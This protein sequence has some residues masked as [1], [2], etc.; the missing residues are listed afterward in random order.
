MDIGITSIQRNRGKWIIEWLA[1]H[2]LVG[3]NKFFIYSHRSTDDMNQKLLKLASFYPIIV[4]EINTDE[5]PQLLAYQHAVNAYLADIDWMA[6]IDGDEFFIPLTKS[7]V[8]EALQPYTSLQLSALA[9]FW[10][11]YGSNGHFNEPNGLIIENY[12]RHSSADFDPNR[13]VKSIVKGREKVTVIG[14][15][16]FQTEFG[17]FDEHLRPIVNGYNPDLQPT[18]EV[19]RINHY[20]LQSYE[21]FKQSKQKM[22][23][24]DC[25]PGASRPDEFFHNHDRNECDDGLMYNYLIPLKLKVAE[26]QRC[27]HD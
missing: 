15:H 18:S 23:L 21:Y 26:L 2:M 4:N 13:H 17:T 8:S 20:L 5:R 7:S 1:F 3:F 6:F 24:A 16:V 11:C 27:L 14:S 25:P 22:G 12:P 10:R 9:V 19:F